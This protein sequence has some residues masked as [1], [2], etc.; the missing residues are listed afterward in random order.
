MIGILMKEYTDHELRA[1]AQRC[2]NTYARI[3]NKFFGANIPIPVPIAFDLCDHN[4]KAAGLACTDM[5]IEINMILFRDNVKEILNDTIPHEI[6][7]LFQFAKFDNKGAAVAGHGAEWQ[8][9]MRRFGKDPSKYHKLDTTKAM[10]HFRQV[11][12]AKKKAE[13][14][15]LKGDGPFYS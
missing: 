4:P 2:A 9:I 10:Q 12:A 1:A 7:H 3:G 6:G 5:H 13:K 15:R 8:E 14:D 11:K